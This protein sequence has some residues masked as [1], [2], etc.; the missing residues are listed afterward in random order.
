MKPNKPRVNQ[1]VVLTA[2]KTK[3]GG[4]RCTWTIAKGVYRKGCQI[5]VRF[6]K[7]GRKHIS[8]RIADR[9]GAVTRA[10][11]DITVVRHVTVAKSRSRAKA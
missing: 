7:P 3:A 9:S 6:A 4:R 10:V 5:A 11:R 1:R 2:P 8:V